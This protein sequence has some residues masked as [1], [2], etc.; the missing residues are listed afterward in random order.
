VERK[1]AALTTTVTLV[2][3]G[4]G[5]KAPLR[6]FARPGAR[7]AL[8]L[9]LDFSGEQDANRQI[10]PTLV[11][12][13]DAVTR[14]VDKDGTA[15]YTITVTGTDARAVNGSPIPLDEFKAVVSRLAGLSISGTR[16][17]TGVSSDV[18]LRV[19]HLE[20]KAAK[21]LE[22]IRLTL[23]TLPRLPKENLGVGAKWKATTAAKLAEKLDITQVTDYE[24]VSHIGATW[25]IKGTTQ[26]SGRD[27]QLEGNKISGIGGTGS[28][29]LIIVDG[30]AY[31]TY[32]AT[33]E[34]QFQASGPNVSTGFVLKIGAAVTPR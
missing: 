25:T 6:Y 9:A 17:A 30:G 11:L 24:V 23:P 19:E 14:S 2:S 16:S 34:T 5:M 7:Q 33:L 28:S 18:T 21:A 13:A 22:L 3:G 8:E 1:V 27:Q 4:T 12:L 15:A 20:D 10:L 31:P 29:E 32:K 26:I